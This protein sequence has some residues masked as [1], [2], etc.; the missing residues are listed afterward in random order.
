MEEKDLL[1]EIEAGKMIREVFRVFKKRIIEQAEIKISIEEFGLL[2]TI[3]KKKVDV[4]QRDLAYILGKNKSF[5]LR[6]TDSLEEKGLVRRVA[7]TTDRRK[8]YLM[9][10]KNGEKAIKKY[11]EIEFE[12]MNELQKGLT[13]SDINTFYKVVNHVRSNSEKL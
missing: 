2:H 7:D 12:L 8:N 3:H 4:I 11:Q 6:L 13:E 1:L 5:I 9:V 10:T